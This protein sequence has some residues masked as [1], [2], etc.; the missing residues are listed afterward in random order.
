MREDSANVMFLPPFPRAGCGTVR[1]WM[2][3]SFDFLIQ[4]I[5]SEIRS[6]PALS[7]TPRP[8]RVSLSG[9]AALAK[10]AGSLHELAEPR[11]SHGPCSRAIARA[12][13]AV[14]S[15]D[16]S[17]PRFLRRVGS[18]PRALPLRRAR[19]RA[20]PPSQSRGWRRGALAAR[21]RERSPARAHHLR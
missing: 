20:G 21:A 9:G 19:D 6:A 15:L 11:S 1:D 14:R 8:A 18:G 4:P 12:A 3:V 16:R 2:T 7:Q 5:E 10:A 17:R 13:L